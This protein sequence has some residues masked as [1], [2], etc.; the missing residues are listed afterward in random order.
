LLG[1]GK[2]GVDDQTDGLAGSRGSRA[3]LL[4]STPQPRAAR[5]N[6]A[7]IATSRRMEIATIALTEHLSLV[8]IVE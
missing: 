3:A 7:M 5:S 1:E 6:S 2:V 4:E 8:G